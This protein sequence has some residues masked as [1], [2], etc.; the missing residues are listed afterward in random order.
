MTTTDFLLAI[1]A[2]REQHRLP[3][4]LR[5]LQ[6]RLATAP[7]TTRIIIVDDGSPETERQLLLQSIHSSRCG[8]CE[9]A[10]PILFPH[11]QGKGAAILTGWRQGGDARW[12]AFADADGATPAYE[13]VR[14][15]D[16]VFSQP[17]NLQCVWASRIRMLGRT[18]K[19][20]LTRHLSGRVFATLASTLLLGNVYDTQCGFKI[21]P[22]QW[23]RK[24]DPEL[25]ESGLC[26]DIELLLALHFSGA[27]VI[28]MP[29]DWEDIAGGQVSLWRDS[30]K[31]LKQLWTLYLRKKEWQKS[32]AS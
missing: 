4:F 18:V 9:V 8:N 32:Q 16:F 15:F 1:P 26:F 13:I 6:D 5:D 2:Y 17:D 10:A 29:V 24:I 25:R 20:K 31:M 21:L 19:R 14:L 11:N 28:E 3:P 27:R 22:V 12:V 30:F 7:Y 23:F